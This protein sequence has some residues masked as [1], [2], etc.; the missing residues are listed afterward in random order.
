MS[1]FDIF[2]DI[3]TELG[4]ALVDDLGAY[5]FTVGTALSDGAHRIKSRTSDG[6]GNHSDFSAELLTPSTLWRR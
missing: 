4:F 3:T 6:L 2:F 5:T 1:F